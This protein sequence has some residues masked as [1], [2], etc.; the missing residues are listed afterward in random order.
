MR[1]IAEC[2]IHIPKGCPPPDAH[3][4]RAFAVCYR[5]SLNGLA[6]VKYDLEL[7]QVEAYEITCIFCYR[8]RL[9]D[10]QYNRFTNVADDVLGQ[11]RHGHR[12][13]SLSGVLRFNAGAV[14]LNV[15][16]GPDKVNARHF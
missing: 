7:L 4:V 8:S 9:C 13:A 14:L 5:A 1:S 12:F 3:I 10:Y 15:R 2:L 6:G 11:E 16:G